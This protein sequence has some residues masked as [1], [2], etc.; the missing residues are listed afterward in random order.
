MK[1]EFH[2]RSGKILPTRRR[3]TKGGYM[4]G[5][6]PPRYYERKGSAIK[7]QQIGEGKKKRFA[8]SKKSNAPSKEYDYPTK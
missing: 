3:P 5:K 2:R 8:F 4:K 6:D 7:D 1:G